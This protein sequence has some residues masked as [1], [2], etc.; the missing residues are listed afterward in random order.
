MNRRSQIV[1]LSLIGT[2]G[3]AA[4]VLPA[5]EQVRRNLYP[6]RAACERDY[7]P[8]Q[9]QP[10]SGGGGSWHGPY[11]STNR[12]SAAARGDPGP[13]RSGQATAVQTST[14]GGFGGF[15]RAGRAGG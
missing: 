10:H 15:G 5:A 2:V 6:D 3:I 14:R 13:G 7:S 12:G 1:L 4:E 8:S 9:C 11:Y